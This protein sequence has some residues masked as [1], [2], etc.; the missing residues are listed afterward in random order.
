[1]RA[2][3]VPP[4]SAESVADQLHH[5]GIKPR[6]YQ[7]GTQRLP[8]PECQKSAKDTALSLTIA[9]DGSAVWFCHRCTWKGRA[10]GRQLDRGYA[11][12]QRQRPPSR[13]GPPTMPPDRGAADPNPVWRNALPIE[14][15]TPAGVYLLGRGCALPHPYADLRWSPSQRHP[16]GYSGPAL[17]ALVTHALTGRP[18]TLHRTWLKPDGSGKADLDKPRLLW[19]GLPTQFGVIRLVP[20][21]ELGAGL[22]VG[23]GIETAL[24][25]ARVFPSAWATIAASNLRCLPPVPGVGALTIVA[26][27]DAVNPRTGERPGIAAA[28]ACAAVWIKAGREVRIWRAPVEGQDINDWSRAA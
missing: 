12:P 4:G 19:K 14:P 10:T 25:A 8:C 6:H 18:M 3:C 13:K 9:G 23:E 21:E 26:D 16:S 2:S 7:A 5:A 20:N 15:D 24:T 1:M 11:M 28:E 22:V 17:V 27:F